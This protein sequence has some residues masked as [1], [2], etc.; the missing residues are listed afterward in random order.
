MV[1][2]CV[3]QEDLPALFGESFTFSLPLLP[4]YQF[5]GLPK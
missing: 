5:R 1:T 4:P 3:A 2:C